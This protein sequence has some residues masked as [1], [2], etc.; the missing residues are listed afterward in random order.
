MRTFFLEFLTFTEGKCFFYVFNSIYVIVF[1]YR[2]SNIICFVR[3]EVFN[4]ICTVKKNNG[5]IEIGV[6]VSYIKMKAFRKG[7]ILLGRTRFL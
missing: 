1:F 7:G 5:I 6:C 4:G 2:N 3:Q